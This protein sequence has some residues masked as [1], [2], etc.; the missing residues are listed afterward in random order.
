[1]SR[2]PQPAGTHPKGI[3]AQKWR[4]FNFP[5][6]LGA[7]SLKRFAMPTG[8]VKWFDTKKGY[9]FI[10]PDDGGKDMFV[11]ITAVQKA[12]YTNLVPGV[13]VSYEL[14]PDREGNPTAE[15]LKIG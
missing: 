7:G 1:L 15:S 9:G 10:V 2:R 11:H 14:R 5:A 8:R 12:G 6:M 13:R 3:A 4:K